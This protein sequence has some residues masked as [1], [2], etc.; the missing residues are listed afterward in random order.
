[1]IS[2]PNYMFSTLFNCLIIRFYLAFWLVDMERM[3]L[4]P[5]IMCLSR[6]ICV[7]ARFSTNSASEKL[8][9]YLHK[10]I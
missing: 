5:K 3:G 4:C 9:C 6:V 8:R 7:P 2:V 10:P 1:M